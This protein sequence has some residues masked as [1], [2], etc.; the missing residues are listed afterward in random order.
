MRRLVDRFGVPTPRHRDGGGTA[1]VDYVETYYS[2]N[3]LHSTVNN[4]VPLE[5]HRV[6]HYAQ[7]VEALAA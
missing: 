5:A 2:G 6:A 4:L 7:A 3:R 1:V